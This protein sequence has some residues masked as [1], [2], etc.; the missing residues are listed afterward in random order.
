MISSAF[1]MLTIKLLEE[2]QC[3]VVVCRPLES[4]DSTQMLQ[5][6]DGSAGTQYLLDRGLGCH[7]TKGP[8]GE[9]LHG[10]SH[11]PSC[12][13]IRQLWLMIP[14]ELGTGMS[15]CQPVFQTGWKRPEM[16]GATAFLNLRFRFG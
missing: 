1:K 15:L 8:Q 5:Q 6:L 2:G 9:I 11:A 14:Q 3:G 13:F 16:Q 4:T 12:S 10:L 7:S